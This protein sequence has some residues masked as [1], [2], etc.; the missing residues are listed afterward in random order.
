MTREPEKENTA[1]RRTLASVEDRQLVLDELKNIL[2]NAHFRGSKR[3]PALLSYVVNAVL[4]GRSGALKERTLGV[5]VF[6]RDP[7]YDTNADPVVRVSAGEVRKRI[8]QFYHENGRSSRVQIELPLGSYVP[9]F[10]LL[11]PDE[12][13]AQA[14]GE[15][16]RPQT[17]ESATRSR[18][19]LAR[20]VVPLI[21]GALL[22]AGAAVAHL[23][24]R[25]PAATEAAIDTLWAP[26]VQSSRPVLIVVGITHP[27][28]MLPEPPQTSFDE[29]L[30]NPNHHFSVQSAIALAH[31]AGTLQQQG[32]GYE[33]KEAPETN[34]TDVHARSLILI[35]G[36]NNEWTMQVMN[37]LRIHFQFDKGAIERI[38]DTQDP[39]QQAWMID[40]FKPY[41]SVTVDYAVVARFRDA[42]TE[43]PVLVIAGLG[44]YGTEAAS[45]FATSP[46]YLEEVRKQLPA[47]WE[48]KNLEVVLKTNVIDGKAG[49]PILLAAT[50]W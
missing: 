1:T 13:D 34:L 49:P 21:V 5:E 31:L 6:G 28:K 37:P 45:E 19:R 36:R 20:L 50:A 26:L 46:Q 15:R 42:T 23:Y 18:G 2:A 10:L 35:G 44:P 41:S 48:S 43:G 29:H 14:A 9:E 32:K 16:G 4:D 33:I 3:Y 7:D 47:G 30:A 39:G 8:A 40:R 12:D 24:R 27:A 11:P 38:E 17:A 25:P 22:A